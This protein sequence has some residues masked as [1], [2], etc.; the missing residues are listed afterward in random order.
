MAGATVAW[1][2]ANTSVATVDGNG[3]VESAGQGATNIVVTAGSTASAS[4]GV[5][6]EQVPHTVV[7]SEPPDSL[8]VGDSIQLTAQAFDALG[9]AIADVTFEW[10]SSDTAIVTVDQRG[11]VRAMAGGSAE[12]T[13]SAGTTASA[14]AEITAVQVP[15]TVVLSEP[16]DSLAVGD[17]IQL[18]AQ[19]FDALGSAIADVTFEWSSSDTAIVTVDQR[20]WVRAMAGGSAEITASAGTTASAVAEITAVQV[21]HTVVLSEPP[22]SLAVGD[23]IQFTAQAFDALGSA[24]ADVTFEWSSSDT[25]IVTVDQR[26]WVRAMAGGSAEITA[27]AG[28][29]A[30]AVAGITAVQV[31]HTVVLS[32]PPDSLAVGDSI[33]LTAQAFDALGSAIADVTFEWSSSDTAIVT[34]DQRGWVRAMAGG[35]AEITAAAGTTASAV[36]GITAVQVPHTVVLSEPPDSLAVGDSIQLTAQAFDALGSAIADVTFEW[37]SSDTTIAAVTQDGW[38][39]GRSAGSVEITVG[40]GDLSA[41]RSLVIYRDQ[42]NPDE[43][44]AL[45]AFYYATNGPEWKNNTNWLSDK[46]V[47]QWYGVE[48]DDSGNVVGLD[49][50]KN[51]LRGRLPVELADL[52]NLKKLFL[53]GEWGGEPDLTGPIPPELG[54]LSNLTVLV[55]GN[56]ELTGEIPP[57]LADLA[58]LTRLSL[59][60]NR[61]TGPIPPELGRLTQ[62][63]D[64]GLGGNLL[65]GKIP[66]ELGNLTRLTELYLADTGLTGHIPRELGNLVELTKL[67]LGHNDLTGVI[68]PELGS[69]AKLEI[70]SLSTLGLTGPIPPVLGGLAQLRKLYLSKN[71]LEGPIPPELGRL[72]NLE[73]LYLDRNSLSGPIPPELGDLSRLEILSLGHNPLTGPIPPELGRLTLLTVLRLNDTRLDGPI[74]PELGNLVGLRTLT[75]QSHSLAGPIPPELGRLRNLTTLVLTGYGISGVIPPEFWNL[76]KLE[77]LTLSYTGLTGSISPRIGNLANLRVLQL[78]Q[79]PGDFGRRGAGF[80]GSLP[81]E[82]GRLSDLLGLR[83]GHHAFTGPLPPEL[84]NLS[85]LR[86]LIIAQAQGGQSRDGIGLTGAIPEELGKL[87]SLEALWLDSNHLS[88]PVPAGLGSLARLIDL[89]LGNN[90]LEGRVPDAFLDLDLEQFQWQNNPLCLPATPAFRAWR[91]RIRTAIGPY[92]AAN[93]IAAVEG[94]RGPWT[95]ASPI[96]VEPLARCKAPWRSANTETGKPGQAE[97][98]VW[99]GGGGRV[100]HDPSIG[101]PSH[102]PGPP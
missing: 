37:S 22:D 13:A 31:P 89:R 82:L 62:L 92:C 17:S 48:T 80:T 68:P 77:W 88:G 41:F 70:L 87:N 96:S 9:S 74:P 21:P 72:H 35:S 34:V 3:L 50:N 61:L 32:E 94:A 27:A 5:M 30:S 23:S 2:S 18:T 73:T 79:A 7:L 91:G 53:W 47:G 57:E 43:R 49:F 19:A 11:W 36:A 76:S 63:E 29:T 14:V 45:E 99:T 6:V 24:I 95:I 59:D 16:P 100:M 25:A 101:C 102:R 15:H 46:P 67:Y 97:R 33:Q 51:G 78:V 85:N 1:V 56:N 44:A 98:V 58:N 64:L 28:T 86:H 69:L 4:V 81:S 40:V 39:D 52:S 93:T 54:A 12:I 26:G 60:Q 71:G 10:S 8:A 75:I 55:L 20:G 66:P 42:D 84:G 38:V 83:I 90:D 65:T